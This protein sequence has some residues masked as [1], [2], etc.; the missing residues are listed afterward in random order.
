MAG[1]EPGHLAGALH[2]FEQHPQAV[3]QAYFVNWN[4]K[5]AKAYRSSDDNAFSSTYR[6][7]LLEDRVKAA[8][9]RRRAR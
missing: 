6:S 7:V 3:D 9:R 5:Q 1:L 8:D 2:A 4:N